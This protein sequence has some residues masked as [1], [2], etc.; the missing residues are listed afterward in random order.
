[1]PIKKFSRD[2][3]KAMVWGD[4]DEGKYRVK[5]DDITGNGRWSIYHDMIF[6]DIAFGRYYLTSYSEGATECQD[7]SPYE[8]DDEMIECR[9]VEPYEKISISYKMV[10]DDAKKS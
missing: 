6:K 3:L 7:E 2:D 10:E 4:H 8:H 9:E 5:I 1:M